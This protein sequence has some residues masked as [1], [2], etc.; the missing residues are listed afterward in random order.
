VKKG[1]LLVKLFDGDLQ[2]QL[3]KAQA[4]LAI[5]KQTQARLSEL[6]TINGVSRSEY[7][8]AVLNVNS[9][10]ADVELISM[11]IQ[12]TEVRAPFNGV[13]GLKQISV[14]AQITPSTPLVTIRMVDRMKVDF[15]VS[16]KYSSEIA[17]GMRLSFSVEGSTARHT[18]T[19]MAIEG[20]IEVTT[21]NLRVR[22]VVDEVAAELKPGAFAK[23][24]LSFGEGRGALMVPTH[25]II[26]EE[27][28]KKVI[29][30]K[31]GRA[32]FITVQTGVR[33][34]T[35]IEVTDGLAAGDTIV[36]TGLLFIKPGAELKFS[37]VVH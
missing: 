10:G 5:A 32:Q 34:D 17:P 33:R 27:R 29:R 23:V 18:A 7:D 14:G 1:T 6:L 2:A 25:A 31:A 9:L 35:V 20:G 16:E 13:L 8:N 3:R 19:V 11:Q 21:R 15:S 12:K 4:Q 24:M 26:P 28:D 30:A 22:A 36:T 37:R